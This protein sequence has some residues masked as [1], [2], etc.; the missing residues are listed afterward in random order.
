MDVLLGNYIELLVAI[1]HLQRASVKTA[2]IWI[3]GWLVGTGGWGRNG[4]LGTH[5]WVAVVPLELGPKHHKCPAGRVHMEPLGLG[6]MGMLLIFEMS[7]NFNRWS[8]PFSLSQQDLQWETRDAQLGCYSNINPPWQGRWEFK[9]HCH[10][11]QL[12][13]PAHLV[14]NKRRNGSMFSICSASASVDQET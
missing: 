14:R 9:V 13:A 6:A 4:N 1:F 12:S 8:G 5:M 3:L 2:W 7:S 10:F 11:T